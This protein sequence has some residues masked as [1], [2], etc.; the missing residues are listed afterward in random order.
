MLLEQHNKVYAVDVFTGKE[1]LINKK[2]SPIQDKYIEKYLTEKEAGL[3]AMLDVK[4]PYSI[5][6]F[7]VIVAPNNVYP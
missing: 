4:L 7:V 3:T 2:I 1:E 6:D 5:A